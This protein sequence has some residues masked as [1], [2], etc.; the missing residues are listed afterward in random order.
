MTSAISGRSRRMRSSISLARA[1]ASES[2]ARV[3]AER[4]ERDEALVG[5]EE[6]EP[7]GGAPVWP[8]ADDPPR[9]VDGVRLDARARAVLGERLDVRLHG[10]GL[11][12][13]LLDRALDLGRDGVRLLEREVARQLEVERDLR[14]RPT[15]STV[16]LCTSRTRGT[17]T[18]AACARSRTAA[19]SSGSTWTTTSLSGSAA[20]H[21]RLD[22]VGGA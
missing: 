1:C 8:R 20:L 5:A 12:H 4:E 7:R 19:S 6:A 3:E 16:T 18:A 10:V 9:T 21:R 15:V 22:R 17:A 14:R 13:R 2:A 11:R